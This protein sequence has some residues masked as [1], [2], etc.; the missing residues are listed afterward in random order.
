MSFLPQPVAVSQTT[1]GFTA[2]Q[3]VYFTGSAW[4]L[5]KSNAGTTLGVG[6]VQVV[7]ANTF[8]VVQ[9][10]VIA[11]LNSLTAGQ[12]YFV[13]DATAGALTA[14]EPTA[15]SSFSNPLLFALTTTTGIVLPFRPSALSGISQPDWVVVAKSTTYGSAINELVCCTTTGAGFTVTLPT[16]VGQTGRKCGVSK[17]SSDANAVTVATTSSQTIGGTG[18]TSASLLSADD[19]LTVV[20]DGANWVIA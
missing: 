11:G 15:S 4:A 3:P 2:G 6:L 16:A 8:N 20:S 19:N 1:H 17:V 5:A 9:H 13:S 12:Y 14:T 7:D 18:A 10:G